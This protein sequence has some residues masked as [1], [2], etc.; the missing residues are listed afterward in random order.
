M[1][2]VFLT[3]LTAYKYTSLSRENRRQHVRRARLKVS[4][5]VGRSSCAVEHQHLSEVLEIDIASFRH[6]AANTA[7]MQVHQYGQNPL[8]R[9]C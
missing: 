8:Q 5:T 9:I 6:H 7:A 4:R 2:T 3:R 1:H